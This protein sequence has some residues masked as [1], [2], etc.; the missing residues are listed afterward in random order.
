MLAFADMMRKQIVMPA[1]LMDDG[2]HGILN[3]GRNLFS[4]FSE[5][6]ERI[7]VYS[8]GDYCD[9]MEHL[10]VRWDVEHREGLRGEAAEAQEY[11]MKLPARFRKLSERAAARKAKAKPARVQFSWIFDK[12]LEV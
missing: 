2:K 9:I 5:V 4:D 10:V 6:A 7:G 3:A 12:P 1:H 11:L 8:A